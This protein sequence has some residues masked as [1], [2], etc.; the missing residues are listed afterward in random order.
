MTPRGLLEKISN[1]QTNTMFTLFIK[2]LFKLFHVFQN[3]QEDKDTDKLWQ[4]EP[5]IQ[6]GNAGRPTSARRKNT[7]KKPAA[8][9]GA[10]NVETQ[11]SQD[12]QILKLQNEELTQKI[13]RLKDKLYET[14]ANAH[15]EL[16]EKE[17]QIEKLTTLLEASRG[18][19]DDLAKRLVCLIII[20]FP[21]LMI[22]Y[23]LHHCLNKK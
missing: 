22:T 4:N 8:S 23:N 7:D 21:F 13:N 2:R 6:A 19:N 14:R 9:Y 11:H 17:D 1:F 16:K 15:Y 12:L 10:R 20:F 18:Q 3:R 5:K